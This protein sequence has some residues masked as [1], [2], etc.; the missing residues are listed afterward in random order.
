MGLGLLLHLR[1][2]RDVLVLCVPPS[3]C[4]GDATLTAKPDLTRYKY[5]GGVTQVMS[6][7]VMLGAPPKSR[8]IVSSYRRPTGVF[9]EHW[10]KNGCLD[11]R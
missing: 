4:A 6:G 5:Q 3:P 9:P 8:A 2:F 10:L 11:G 1:V 7:G